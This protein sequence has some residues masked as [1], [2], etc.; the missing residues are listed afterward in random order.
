MQRLGGRAMTC[1][2][3]GSMYPEL[4]EIL[5]QAKH[6][7]GSLIS[8]LHKAQESYGYLSTDVME[9]IAE[10]MKLP[11][12]QVSGVVSF[13]AFF[14]TKEKGKYAVSVCLG[15]AC[16][17]KGANDV[18]EACKKHLG[19]NVGETTEDGLF[20][21]ELCHC[22]GACSLAPVLTVNGEI[23]GNVTPAGVP[24]LLDQYRDAEHVTE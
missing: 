17:V 5:E 1:Q 10:Q 24:A 18:M 11:L 20:T 16:H 3:G 4:D 8:V 7:A 12:S 19:L 15:T 14:S 6:E 2:C 23:H 9:Y 22:V 13:Y 21:L